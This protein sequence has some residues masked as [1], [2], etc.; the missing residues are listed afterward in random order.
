MVSFGEG[1]IPARFMVR[2]NRFLARVD[3]EGK[4]KLAHLPNT[5]RLKEILT[6]GRR[7]YLDRADNPKRKTKY[8]ALL[9]DMDG[10]LVSIDS[11]V[12]NRMV[13]EHLADKKFPPFSGYDKIKKEWKYENSRFDLILSQGKSSKES[14][15]DKTPDLVVEVKGVTLMRDSVALFPDAETLRGRKHLMELIKLKGMGYRYRAA[16]VFVAQREDAT[17]FS[18]NA[19]NDPRFTEALSEA[20]GGGVE[21]YAFASVVTL[22]GIEILREIP[23][24]L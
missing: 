10:V 13:H 11:N 15:S 6:E 16:V 18:P 2:E 5:G 19:E 20:K 9:A 24:R 14:S 21:I 7:L 8:T 1:L 23:V 4:V 3:V 12:V 22:K 17:S